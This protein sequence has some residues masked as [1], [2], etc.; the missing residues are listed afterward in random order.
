LDDLIRTLKDEQMFDAV[1]FVARGQLSLSTSRQN[2]KMMA[3]SNMVIGET[4][5]QEFSKMPGSLDQAK[6]NLL[7]AHESYQKSSAV[8]SDDEY[9]RVCMSLSTLFRL[10]ENPGESKRFLELCA[11]KSKDN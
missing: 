5:V 10:T 9:C 1:L 4:L 2:K 6:T 11:S 3:F 7:D 8:L